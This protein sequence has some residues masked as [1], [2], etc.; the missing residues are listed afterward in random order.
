MRV[1]SAAAVLTSPVANAVGAAQDDRVG[2]LR[3]RRTTGS[4]A[5]RADDDNPSGATIPVL[6][7]GL[8]DITTQA[9]TDSQRI[10][11]PIHN[12]LG[13]SVVSM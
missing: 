2:L 10:R 11:G 9:E 3:I 5:E 8:Y 12:Y 7:Q 1:G 4:S 6:L 13:G